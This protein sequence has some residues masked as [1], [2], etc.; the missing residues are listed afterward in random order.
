LYNITSVN[1]EVGVVLDNCVSVEG[2]CTGTGDVTIAGDQNNLTGSF[3]TGLS[4][5]TNGKL[6]LQNVTS[7]GWWGSVV[8]SYVSTT[9]TAIAAPFLVLNSTGPQLQFTLS[10]ANRES[11]FVNLP[12]GDQIQIFCPVSGTAIIKRLENTMLPA[13]LPAGYNYTSAFSLEILQR[14]ADIPFISEGG[15][16]RMSFKL[17]SIKEGVSYSILYW[18][19]GQWLELQSFIIDENGKPRVFDL[20]ANRQILSGMNFVSSGEFPYVEV[21]TNFPG[22]FA[23]AQH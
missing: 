1:N 17:P 14:E 19:N 16:T 9:T 5:R 10:C 22:I 12:N 13:D 20:D 4:V 15:Y 11:F 2:I 8:G 7:D 6:I 23:L 21:S 18:D 3:Y